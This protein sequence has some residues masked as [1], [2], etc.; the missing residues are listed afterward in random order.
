MQLADD[1]AA[2]GEKLWNAL[3]EENKVSL[4]VR[5]IDLESGETQTKLYNKNK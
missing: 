5:S 3:N 4:F 1:F 2:F